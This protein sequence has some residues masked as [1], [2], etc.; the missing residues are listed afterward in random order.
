MI[1]RDVPDDLDA[2]VRVRIDKQDLIHRGDHRFAVILGES[3]L[4]YR[5]GDTDTM[6]GQLGHPLTVAALPSVTAA[7]AASNSNDPPAAFSEE[8]RCCRTPRSS[9]SF[10]AQR[11]EKIAGTER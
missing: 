9:M 7:I 2:P 11:R 1:R 6:A 10:P 5:I 8:T 3:V 4:H